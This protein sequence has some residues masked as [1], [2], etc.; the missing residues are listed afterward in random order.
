ML[1]YWL[2]D[3]VASPT[4][5]IGNLGFLSFFVIRKTS[6]V[7]IIYYQWFIVYNIHHSHY[8]NKENWLIFA[9]AFDSWEDKQS[10]Y[11]GDWLA[12]IQGYCLRTMASWKDAHLGEISSQNNC[13]RLADALP[14][15]NGAMWEIR[16]RTQIT[17]ALNALCTYITHH[18][19]AQH[20]VIPRSNHLYWHKCFLSQR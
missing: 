12:I 5:V 7:S 2:L 6:F 14:S 11:M 3:I 4:G 19:S 18:P 16:K 9:W 20:N 1:R 8:V 17:H 15:H 13:C 10:I